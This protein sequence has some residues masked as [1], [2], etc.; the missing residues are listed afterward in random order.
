MI[1]V[2]ISMQVYA[3]VLM[4][5]HFSLRSL[6]FWFNHVYTHEGQIILRNIFFTVCLQ[7]FVSVSFSKVVCLWE[8]GNSSFFAVVVHNSLVMVAFLQ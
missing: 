6:E 4:C 2:E 5:L 1:C 7:S 3:Y 8:F